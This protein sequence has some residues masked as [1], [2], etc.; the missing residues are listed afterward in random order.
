MTAALRL[1]PQ[2]DGTVQVRTGKVELG[3][4][5]L[6]ALSQIAADEL[7]LHPS[8]VRMLAADTALAPEEGVTSGSLSVQDAGTALRQA[9]RAL[10]ASIGAGPASTPEAH[11]VGQP[12]PRADLVAKLS[13]QPA[14]IHDLVLPGMLHGRVL[15]PPQRDALLIAA[16]TAGAAAV[17]GVLQVLQDG[18]LLGPIHRN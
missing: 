18:R 11:W 17:P 2:P 14:F 8:Q 5:I 12:W 4:G 13:G 6:T 3:Q 16:D 7:G 1:S 15:H 10:Q 9:C